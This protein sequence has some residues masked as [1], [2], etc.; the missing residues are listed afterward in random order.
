MKHERDFLIDQTYVGDCCVAP[1]PGWLNALIWLAAFL[2][3]GFCW[4][5]MI[6]MIV[7]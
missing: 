6:M 1:Y 3:G 7:H 4:L 5:G 2:F